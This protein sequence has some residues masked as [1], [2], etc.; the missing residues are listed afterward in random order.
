MLSALNVSDIG[1]DSTLVGHYGPEQIVTMI[2]LAV[3]FI[4]GVPGNSLVIWVTSVKMR[5]TVNTV[6]FWNL[7]VADLICCLSLPFS[8]SVEVLHDVW[9]YG[10]ILCKLLPSIVILN[11]FASVFT[12]VT[13]SVDRCLLVVKPVWSQ[14]NRTVQKAWLAC[15]CIWLLSFLMC[16]P[17]FLYRETLLIDE[18]THCVYNYDGEINL[19]YSYN[20]RGD[21]FI[22]KNATSWEMTDIKLNMVNPVPGG[23]YQN[24]EYFD[25]SGAY[26]IDNFD[27]RE[28]TFETYIYNDINRIEAS[29]STNAIITV[30]VTR[31]ILGF[32]LPFLIITACYLC[33]GWKLQN[34]RF[35]KVGSKT[36]KVATGIVIA[37]C[38]SWAPYH[39]VGIGMLF[40]ESPTLRALDHLSQGLAYANCC[41]NPILYVFM[42]KDFKNKLQK[43]FH[44]L[45][46]SVF[47]E[48]VTRTTGHDKSEKS[49]KNSTTV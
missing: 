39:I 20:I 45:M 11:M 9:P 46:E 13:I 14:N 42:G 24:E 4:F 1:Q 33:L 34:S 44:V 37:F 23:V 16:L 40:L 5:R 35:G 10:S 8:I 15:V 6:W 27:T 43:S 36:R 26:P 47:S 30:T 32:F 2:I 31:A 38:V 48:E 18:T 49:S 17:V 29:T 21:F 3:T 12:L 25:V 19:N 28:G 7:A 41:V 22:N